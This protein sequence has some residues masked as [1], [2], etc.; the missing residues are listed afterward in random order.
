MEKTSTS[1]TAFLLKKLQEIKTMQ[2]GVTQLRAT[3]AETNQQ[4]S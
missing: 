2:A 1:T 4:G 3:K